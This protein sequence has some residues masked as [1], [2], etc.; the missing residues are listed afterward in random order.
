MLSAPWQN[1]GTASAGG[2]GMSCGTRPTTATVSWRYA[3][4]C[5]LHASVSGGVGGRS[6]APVPIP[7]IFQGAGGRCSADAQG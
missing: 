2:L 3:L 7:H 1:A 4:G 6:D 5:R